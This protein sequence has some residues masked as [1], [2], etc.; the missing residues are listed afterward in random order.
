MRLCILIKYEKNLQNRILWIASSFPKEL[1]NHLANWLYI[2]FY[3][4]GENIWSL[5]GFLVP[6]EQKGDRMITQNTRRLL[7]TYLSNKENYFLKEWKNVKTEDTFSLMDD[8]S[9]SKANANLNLKTKH[10][11]LVYI[12]QHQRNIV[13]ITCEFNIQTTKMRSLLRLK[14]ARHT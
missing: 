6:V 10:N 4:R 1:T 13:A 11:Y 14:Y 12:Y 8:K 2:H 3:L 7:S 5:I 9:W